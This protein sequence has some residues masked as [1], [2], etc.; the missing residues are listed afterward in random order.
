MAYWTRVIIGTCAIFQKKKKLRI[1]QIYYLFWRR[2]GGG[3]SVI[4]EKSVGVLF[5][6]LLIFSLD[7][8]NRNKN[9]RIITT[10]YNIWYLLYYTVFYLFSVFTAETGKKCIMKNH[11][12]FP[13]IFLLRI[14]FFIS[15]LLLLHFNRSRTRLARLYR[16]R[17]PCTRVQSCSN[18]FFF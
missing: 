7:L 1:Y 5:F 11:R 12:P 16:R 13:R 14:I 4:L 8:W 3:G 6:Y 9:H 10:T 15:N 17:P 18:N 2:N